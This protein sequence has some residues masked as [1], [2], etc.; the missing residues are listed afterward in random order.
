LASSVALFIYWRRDKPARR[1]YRDAIFVALGVT[2]GLLALSRYLSHSEP[3][4]LVWS[5]AVLALLSPISIWES[6]RK[7]ARDKARHT[8]L[9]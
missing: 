6:R 2:W 3:R 8:E 7:D 1:T 4:W 9:D 5:Y